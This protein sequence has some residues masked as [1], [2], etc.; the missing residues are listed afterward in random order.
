MVYLRTVGNGGASD[1]ARTAGSA[2]STGAGGG[3]VTWAREEGLRR[4]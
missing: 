4:V 2:G 3:G 1:G